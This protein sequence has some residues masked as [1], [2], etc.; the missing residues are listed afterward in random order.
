[1]A[2]SRRSLRLMEVFRTVFYTP[3]YVSVAGGF[4]ENQGLDVTFKTCPP[5]FA[6]VSSALDQGAADI[7]GSGIMSSIISADGGADTVPA[8]FAKINARDGFFILSRRTDAQFQWE[9]LRGA[10]VI[11]VG[12]SPMPPASLQFALRNHGV[13]PAELNLIPGLP[14]DEAVAIFRSGQGDFIHLPEPAAEQQIADGTAS[15]AVALGPANGHIAYSSFAATTYFL[16][17]NPDLVDSFM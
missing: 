2:A 9:T 11:P 16:D 8:H 14:L 15:L 7:S 5:Q 17:R 12:F 13:D 3:I 10:T 4:L 1:M 6:N